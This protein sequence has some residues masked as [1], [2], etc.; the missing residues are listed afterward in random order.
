M[1]SRDLAAVVKTQKA[2]IKGLLDRLEGKGLAK[3]EPLIFFQGVK[4]TIDQLQEKVKRL[5][6]F[7]SFARRMQGNISL[8]ELYVALN[9]DYFKNVGV[10]EIF[11]L[12][13]KSIRLTKDNC[14]M[15]HKLEDIREI[16]ED[17]EIDYEKTCYLVK[18]VLDK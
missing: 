17:T 18:D 10:K 12:A 7:E 1:R 8:P 6:M 11:E 15:T 4:I 13:K 14:D 2:F 3:E 9:D 16:I 5:E